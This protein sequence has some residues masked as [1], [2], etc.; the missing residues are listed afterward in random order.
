MART[1]DV[2]P[3]PSRTLPLDPLVGHAWLGHL[4][5][6]LSVA[7]GA[8]VHAC[9]THPRL[10]APCSSSCGASFCCWWA[11]S[12]WCFGPRS[13]DEAAQWALAKASAS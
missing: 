12:G 4:D 10:P 7:P 2:S 8:E 1:T 6:F 13:S 9:Q 5:A 3:Q 11:L